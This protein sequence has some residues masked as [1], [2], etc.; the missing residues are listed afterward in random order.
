MSIFGTYGSLHGNC[1]VNKESNLNTLRFQVKGKPVADFHLEVIFAE[2]AK[3]DLPDSIVMRIG[4]K[5][6]TWSNELKLDND[7]ALDQK[8]YGSLQHLL[9]IAKGEILYPLEQHLVDLDLC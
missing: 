9:A 8:Q 5:A 3:T 7:I 2:N 1:V 6:F 4:S